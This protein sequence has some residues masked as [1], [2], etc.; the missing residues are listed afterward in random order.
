M[1]ADLLHTVV[2]NLTRKIT[3]KN[4]MHLFWYNQ[5]HVIAV[6]EKKHATVGKHAATF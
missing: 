3:A 4:P 1:R 2:S 5:A 6:K